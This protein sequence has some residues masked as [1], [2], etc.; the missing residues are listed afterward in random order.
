MSILN[1]YYTLNNGIKIPKIGYGTWQ[2]SNEQAYQTTLDA[3]EVGYRHIDTAKAYGNES[4][5]GQ[6]IRDSGISREEIFVTTKL[7]APAKGYQETLD[8]FNSQIETLGLNYVDLYII[9]A[10]WPWSDR[11]N[12]VTKA[13]QQA[14]LAMEELLK[15]NKVKAIG[16]SN[17]NVFDLQAIIE[18]CSVTPAVNQIRYSI[19]FT[20]DK[21]VEFCNEHN[22]LI[23]AYSPLGSGGAFNHP[24]LK[25]LADKL[26][27]SVAQLCVRYT[28]EKGTLPLPKT[29]SKERMIENASVDFTLSKDILEQLD[30]FEDIRST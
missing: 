22:I 11:G 9:H 5:V 26:H 4:A 7:R 24:K 6:A 17:F 23:E 19:G 20:Q 28:L 2:I 14:Y 18:V 12:S 8:A 13:N 29:L 27:I 25:E 3:L 10:P 15:Q 21:I 16:V 1:E 30:Q